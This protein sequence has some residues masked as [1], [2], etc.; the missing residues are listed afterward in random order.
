M[1]EKTCEFA[2]HLFSL[3]IRPAIRYDLQNS[4]IF[5]N[6]INVISLISDINLLIL[7]LDF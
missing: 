1:I 2:S 3:L 6:I 7:F 5:I 4:I